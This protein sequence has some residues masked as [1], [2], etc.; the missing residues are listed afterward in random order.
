MF[1][2]SKLILG[3]DGSIFKSSFDKMNSEQMNLL[4]RPYK[5]QGKINS[6]LLVASKHA[7]KKHFERFWIG[8]CFYRCYSWKMLSDNCYGKAVIK[9]GHDYFDWSRDCEMGV[10]CDI[11][12]LSTW[13]LCDAAAPALRSNQLQS[14]TWGDNISK[15][16][17]WRK[18]QFKLNLSHHHDKGALY[19]SSLHHS[20]P[21]HWR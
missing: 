3:S 16:S 7:F 19:S 4:G 21:F 15:K 14:G 12:K 6:Q 2:S 5:C 13:E 18:I 11:S 20:D 1:W 8:R 10:K 9:L 17:T